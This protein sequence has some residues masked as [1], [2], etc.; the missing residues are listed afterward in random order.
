MT[1]MPGFFTK[2]LAESD[3]EIAKAIGLELS[4]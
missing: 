1:L 2:T 3:P 4:R